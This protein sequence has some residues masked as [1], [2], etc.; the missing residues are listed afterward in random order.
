MTNQLSLL[1]ALTAPRLNAARIVTLNC[2]L[3]RDSIAMLCLLEE[4]KLLVEGRE[5]G[6]QDIDYVVF[7]DVGHEW[8]H[9]YDLIPVIAAKCAKM[10]V[11]FLV[12][13]KGETEHT[14]PASVEDAARLRFGV[15]SNRSWGAL[16]RN[17]KRQPHLA[18]VGIAADE[19]QRIDKAEGVKGVGYMTEAYPLFDMGLSKGDEAAILERHGLN[20]VRKS[21]CYLCPFQP[22]GWYWALSVTDPT[23][24]QMVVEYEATAL[25]NNPKMHATGAKTTIPEMVRQW[26]ENNPDATVDEVLDKTYKMCAQA[27]RAAQRAA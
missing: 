4:G 2:G 16:V 10:G 14:I 3:G 5:I 24:Y 13:R 12:L 20:H 9:T 27:A 6:P 19:K 23:A 8:K 22:P 7:S 18:L 17:G 11:S 15:E 26:R 21:G 1:D 25:A